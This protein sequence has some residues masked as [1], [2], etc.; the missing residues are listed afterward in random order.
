MTKKMKKLKILVS[1]RLMT[2]AFATLILTAVD[3]KTWTS[4]DGAKSFEGELKSYD[5]EKGL[6]TVTLP[7]GKPINF[8]E[9]ILA[10]ADIAYLKENGSKIAAAAT[11]VVNTKDIPDVW[12]PTDEKPY[13][14]KNLK[15]EYAAELKSLLADLSRS[16]PKV[17]GNGFAELETAVKASAEAEAKAEAAQKE[18]GQ[19]GGA[20][21]LID[22]AKGKWI[23]GANKNIADAQAAIKNAKSPAEKSAAERSLAD[24]KKNLAD[25]EAALKER[26]E[27][28]EKAKANETTLKKNHEQAQ[29]VLAEAKNRESD[30]AKKLIGSMS[31]FLSSNSLDGKLAKAFILTVS[32]PDGLGAF[33]DKSV[34]NAAAVEQLL[35]NDELMMEMMVAGGARYGKFGEAM[36]I[37]TTIQKISPQAKDGVLRRFALATS[38]EHGQPVKANLSPNVADQSPNIHPIKRYL[39]YEKAYL[40]DELDPAFK[41]L[42]TWEMRFVANSEDPDEILVWGREMLRTYRPDHIYNPDYGWRYV[43]SVRTEV[44]YGSQNVKFDDPS[45][46]QH[47]NIIRNGG[48]CGRR[49]FYGRFILRSFGIPT[50]G[51]TQKAHAAL[52]HWTPKGWVVNLGAGF[53]HSWWDKDEEKLSGSQFLLETQARAHKDEY[54]KIVRAEMVSRILGEK[55]YNERGNE[56]G[57]HWSNVALNLSRLLASSTAALGPL[58]Q[59]LAEANEKEQELQSEATSKEDLEI[60]EKGG[61][62]TVPV[63][64]HKS[65]SGKSASMRSFSGGMQIH[66]FGGFNAEYKI[67]AQ[68]SGDYLLTAKV[69]TAQTGQGFVY[70]VNDAQP[71]QQAAPYT[72]GVWKN[73]E[74]IPV[75]LKSGSNTLQF[76]ITDGSRGVTLKEF[77][78][79]PAR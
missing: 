3:A 61:V 36:K 30:A 60:Q 5:A 32:T 66:A 12:P 48:V 71:V 16:L 57:G 59:E 68:R 42:N 29:A 19:I 69:A 38:L 18:F 75:K 23:G 64:A 73:S 6:V 54:I 1:S 35:A 74:A 22:H 20:K 34:V 14:G 43:S 58:G 45:N 50:W 55:A 51:V 78:L 4:A 40:A 11:T 2:A 52:S 63:I 56:Q 28:Y 47:Q 27:A 41:T 33:A 21:A 15:S 37:F 9:K 79:T 44:P 46:H 72:I 26:T 70:T 76:Q 31:S 39:Q 65:I 49:A 62:I 67:Q 7:N 13:N 10:P 8:S 17:G 77:T 24:A 25:G 53:Q